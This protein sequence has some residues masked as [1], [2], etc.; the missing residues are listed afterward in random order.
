VRET[1]WNRLLVQRR[2]EHAKNECNRVQ[3][4]ECVS[5]RF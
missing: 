4:L 5:V 1:G 2:L 3:H